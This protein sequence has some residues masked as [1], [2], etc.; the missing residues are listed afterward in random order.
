MKKVGSFGLMEYFD[1]NGQKYRT[2]TYA[3]SSTSP[4]YGTRWCLN[5]A[6]LKAEFILCRLKAEP[7]AAI[8][9]AS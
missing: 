9:E 7:A 2:I 8:S 3:P 1:Y 6:T 5:M 4:N